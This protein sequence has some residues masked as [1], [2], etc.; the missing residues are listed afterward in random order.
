MNLSHHGPS[1][2]SLSFIV[3]FVALTLVGC[4]DPFVAFN[5]VPTVE[6]DA[7]ASGSDAGGSVGVAGS[8]VGAAGSGAAQASGAQ[9][10]SAGSIATSVGGSTTIVVT[11]AGGADPGVEPNVG[12]EGPVGTG[13]E[14]APQPQSVSELIDDMEGAFPHLPQSGGRNGGWYTTHD[15]TY[16]QVSPARAML[17]Q[18]ARGTSRF[19][20]EFAG[21]GFTDWGAQ[22]GVSLRSP[23]AGYDA[24]AFCGVRFMV[25][26]SGSGWSFLISDRQSVP[27]G[28]VCDPNAWGNE[29]A[30][31]QFVGKPFEAK[32]E[33]QEVVVRF[34]ELK[35]LSHPDRQ[36]ALDTSAIYDIIFNFYHHDGAAFQLMVDDLSFIK[37]TASGCR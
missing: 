19:A 35:L 24:S 16:G 34:N 12:G 27:E 21:G 25:K 5:D 13:G 31:Y 11:N 17:L 20:A 3:P 18:P 32:A 1:L 7:G 9:P 10:G 36:R 30:C 2:S 14:P 8:G 22:L 28:G 26:G 4:V 23:S 6:G 37:Q 15:S 33:W 29:D